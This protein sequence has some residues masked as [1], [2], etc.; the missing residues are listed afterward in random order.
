MTGKAITNK[1]ISILP[2]NDRS[3]YIPIKTKIYALISY[4]STGKK[5]RYT[6]PNWAIG[7]YGLT[8]IWTVYL[9]DTSG[10]LCVGL[11]PISKLAI[12]IPHNKEI[13]DILT[14]EEAHTKFPEYFI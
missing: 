2:E 12:F 11:E 3:M 14:Y 8:T 10:K 4:I 9:K 13:L 6:I 1:L 5:R 7:Y